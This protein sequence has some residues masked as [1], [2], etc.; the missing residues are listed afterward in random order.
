MNLIR[1]DQLSSFGTELALSVP[2]F[3]AALIEIPRRI[4]AAGVLSCL[5]DRSTGIS[6]KG[7]NASGSTV[8]WFDPMQLRRLAS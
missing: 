7:V 1:I 8:K 3:I 2:A 5:R 4:I 6:P